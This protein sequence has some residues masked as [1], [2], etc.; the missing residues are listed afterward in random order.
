KTNLLSA[1]TN[2]IV[3]GDFNIYGST[4]SAYQKL[5]RDNPSDDGNFND[6]LFLT[7]IWNSFSFRYYH[8][9]STR[10]RSFGNGSTGGL[11][12][13]FDMILNSNAVKNPG[14]IKFIPGSYV[15]FGNDG[16]HYNDSINKIPNNAVPQAVADALHYASDHLP[17]F[18]MFEFGNAT[19]INIKVIPEGLYDAALNRLNR[20]DSISVYLRNIFPPYS[21]VDSSRAVIDSITFNAATIF[22]KAQTGS[23]YLA[24]KTINSIETWS[25][26]GG[27]P[28]Y[29]D[30]VMSYDFTISASQAFGNNLILKGSE[31]CI[32]SGDINSDAFV[33]LTDILLTYNDAVIFFTGYTPSDVN[34]DNTV[35]LEDLIIVNNNSSNFVRRITP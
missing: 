26:A 35:N 28:F 31:Y 23:Y 1:G 12:D 4:E 18:A 15:S 16:N 34:G 8:T 25:T 20:R 7:G 9:Q 33:N 24:V 30:S 3:L 5:I 32:Y 17:V 14:G 29:I 13:R 22:R 11:D 21:I 10:T 2:F 6:P 19:T 27:T